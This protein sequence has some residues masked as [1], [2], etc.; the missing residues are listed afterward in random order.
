MLIRVVINGI[1][2][3]GTMTNILRNLALYILKIFNL[4]FV[5]DSKRRRLN[6]ESRL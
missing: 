4:T 6:L 5:L 1:W 3:S 2:T